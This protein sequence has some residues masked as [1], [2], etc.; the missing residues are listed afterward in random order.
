M[1]TRGQRDGLAVVIPTRNR[2]HLLARC[3]EELSGSRNL[4]IVVIVDSSDEN[5][6]RIGS[7]SIL[8]VAKSNPKLTIR[9]LRHPVRSLTH[10]KNRALEALNQINVAAFQVVDDDVLIPGRSLDSMFEVLMSNPEYVG[11]SGVTKDSQVGGRSKSWGFYLDLGM[12]LTARKP[13][14]IS[15]GG[16]GVPVLF[17]EVDDSLK[18]TESHW[19]IGC[20]MFNLSLVEGLRYE[21]RFTGSGLFEDVDYSI[22]AGR[23]GKLLTT[24]LLIEH[25]LDPLNRPN[26]RIF[27]QRFAQN[28]HLVCARLGRRN[29]F[30]FWLGSLA[31]LVGHGLLSPF[32]RSSRNWSIGTFQGM[33]RIFTRT[34]PQ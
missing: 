18:V 22:R 30:T 28:R 29:L 34:W 31:L 9:H 8:D 25:H 24:N 3:I 10:Q 7:R 19:L 17:E 32:R 27:A 5:E 33:L 13:G 15:L 4:R 21:E 11:I 6:F 20:S 23:L 12:G 1:V 2:P 14:K 26:E 16:C